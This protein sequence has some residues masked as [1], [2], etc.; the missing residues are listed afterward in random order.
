LKI[1]L[2]LVFL[3]VVFGFDLIFF[4]GVLIVVCVGIVSGKL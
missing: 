3:G 2:G 4:M 1:I